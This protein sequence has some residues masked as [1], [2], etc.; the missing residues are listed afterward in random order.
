[1]KNL[2]K[3]SWN[4]FSSRELENGCAGRWLARPRDLA[5][6]DHEHCAL[7]A[8]V[9]PLT[10]AERYLFFAETIEPHHLGAA[11]RLV[12]RVGHRRDRIGRNR[13]GVAAD[14]ARGL[15]LFAVT[16]GGGLGT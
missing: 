1:M 15:G 8:K 10:T 5:V 13:Q 14:F 4:L 2:L 11:C 7:L 12:G 3:I 9:L 6:P 16:A